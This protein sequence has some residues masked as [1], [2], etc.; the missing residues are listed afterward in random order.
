MQYFFHVLSIHYIGILSKN[1]C[2]CTFLRKVI[3]YK[4]SLM[5][6]TIICMRVNVM[7]EGLQHIHREMRVFLVVV[8]YR[9]IKPNT[10][11]PVNYFYTIIILSI[12]I[13][14]TFWV[15]NV[16]LYFRESLLK[17]STLS[18]KGTILSTDTYLLFKN[19][20]FKILIYQNIVYLLIW[21]NY[22]K[23]LHCI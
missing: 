16:S 22:L 13:R 23:E 14:C 7:Y 8:D 4:Y 9:K 11:K 19:F 12:S 21:N 15:Y 18:I 20:C 5:S 6:S 10:Q 3:I 1:L 2:T 17:S